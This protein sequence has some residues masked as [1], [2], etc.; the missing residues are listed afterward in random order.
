MISNPVKT[1]KNKKKFRQ[2]LSGVKVMSKAQKLSLFAT[3]R[4]YN[5]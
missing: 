2:L 4:L 1:V 5:L 3:I